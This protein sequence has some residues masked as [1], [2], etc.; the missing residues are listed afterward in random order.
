MSKCST[1]VWRVPSVTLGYIFWI[2]RGRSF[3]K[4]IL[5]DC[6]LCKLVLGKPV[7]PPPTPALPDYRLHCI[8]PFQIIGIDYG[9]P[10]YVRDVYSRCDELFKYY[11]LSITCAATRALH[12]KLTSDF[13]SNSLILALHQCFA[14]RGTPTQIISDNFK[15]LEVEKYV[16]LHDLIE[17]S[18][19][20]F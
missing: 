4:S 18:E 7:T 3:V 8:F 1:V 16:I 9:G 15:T 17:Y 6:Y 14:R 2:I 13:S 12:I 10:V 5:K 11:F 19:S 20:L